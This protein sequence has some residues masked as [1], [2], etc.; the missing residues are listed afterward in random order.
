VAELGNVEVSG[1]ACAYCLWRFSHGDEGGVTLCTSCGTPY[2]GDCFLENGGCATFGCPAW[3]A[4]QP[5][6]APLVAGGAPVAPSAQVGMEAAAGRHV[7]STL[8][9]TLS[10]DVS[11]PSLV[12]I[13][14]RPNF[15]DQC[16]AELLPTYVFC[17]G[18][19]RQV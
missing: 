8:S 6:G 10:R 19:G 4:Q 13:G 9:P 15:C 16:G 7:P 11:S 17:S 2:H 12:A 14:V 18:C 5:G 3:T 1:A